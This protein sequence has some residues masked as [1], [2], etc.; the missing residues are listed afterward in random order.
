MGTFGSYT[1]SMDLSDEKKEQFLYWMKKVLN[2]GGM[3]EFDRAVMFGHDIC[4]L[5]PIKIDYDVNTEIDFYYNYFEDDTWENAGYNP[6][7][8]YFYSNK[9]GSDEF[10]DVITAVHVLYEVT[11]EKY[12]FAEINGDIISRSAYAGWLNHILGTN[13]SM[14][15]RYRLWDNVERF[16]LER[17]E[18]EYD[19]VCSLSDVKNFIPS[20]MRYAAGGTEFTDLCYIIEGTD[21]LRKEAIAQNTYPEDV[22]N[23]KQA[24]IHYFQQN[25]DK[26][27]I[28]ELW[29]LLQKD[30]TAREN[31]ENSTFAEL[32]KMTLYLPA[33]VFVYLIAEIK[34]LAFWE[35]WKKLKDVV[36]H[37]EQMKQYASDELKEERCRAIEQPIPPVSTCEFLRYD[38][39]VESLRVP[40]EV[41]DKPKYF[42]S[43][44]D[45]LYWWDGSD[46]VKISSD[47]DEWLKELAT[48]HKELMNSLTDESAMQ[49]SFLEKFME[50]LAQANSYY[51]HIYPFQ[52]MFYEFIQ[53][54]TKKEY[55]AAVQL[56]ETLIEDNKEQGKIINYCHGSWDM[57]SRKITHNIGRLRL[58]RFLSVMANKK[59]R[60]MYFGF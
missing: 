17:L 4:L 50:V 16:S 20:T 45:R 56:F 60:E 6:K 42:I 28:E 58:K 7:G 41:E 32:A 47:M 18:D 35:Q 22:Y 33:R 14:K 55:L 27:A 25:T 15:K 8:D 51:K 37:D 2:Y 11:D 43:D 53:N 19:P 1:G 5:N 34:E 9:I 10:N 49:N 48:Q 26:T 30:R 31:I 12:G 13:F 3:M 39:I 23:C 21:T 54:G 44:D 59:L 52:N 40:E 57:Y 38:S 36:Y 24:L 29:K 46:E